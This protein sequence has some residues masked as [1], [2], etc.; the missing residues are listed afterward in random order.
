MTA[1]TL[2]QSIHIGIFERPFAD[3]TLRRTLGMLS[4][5]AKAEAAMARPSRFA[6]VVPHPGSPDI[7]YV[8]CAD[9]DEVFRMIA[10]I[11]DALRHAGVRHIHLDRLAEPDTQRLIDEGTARM[12]Q[13]VRPPAANDP[14]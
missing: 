7:H 2:P 10:E 12:E 14:G 13:A 3:F 9:V 1:R 5:P 8:R 4:T 11:R 6:L